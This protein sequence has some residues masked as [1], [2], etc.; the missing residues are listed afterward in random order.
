MTTSYM[1]KGALLLSVIGLH[2]SLSI[3]SGSSP[4]FPY[5]PPLTHTPG[6]GV[7]MIGAHGSPP[8]MAIQVVKIITP[9]QQRQLDTYYQQQEQLFAQGYTQRMQM[10]TQLQ[11]LLTH[12]PRNTLEQSITNRFHNEQRIGELRVWQ[13]LVNLKN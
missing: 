6:L 3:P 5:I 8:H 13:T 9:M 2:V 1:L 4:V 11:H 7:S 10:Q 12:L